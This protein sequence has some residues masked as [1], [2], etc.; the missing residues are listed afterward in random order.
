[1]AMSFNGDPEYVLVQGTLV[2]DTPKGVRVKIDLI[3][4]S[5]TQYAEEEWWFPR[6][7]IVLS[8]GAHQGSYVD[9]EVVALFLENEGLI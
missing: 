5:I 1:M 3:D 8:T 2:A 4:S 6:Q 7:Y 9:L